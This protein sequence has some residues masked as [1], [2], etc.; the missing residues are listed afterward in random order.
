MLHPRTWRSCNQQPKRERAARVRRSGA[1]GGRDFCEP[2]FLCVFLRSF[3]VDSSSPQI[4]AILFVRF[5][6]T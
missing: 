6:G 3:R 2:G 5:I 4:S 1:P